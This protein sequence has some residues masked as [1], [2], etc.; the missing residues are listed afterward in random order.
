[1][2]LVLYKYAGLSPAACWTAAITTW[3]G[4]W[5]IFEPV[6]IPATSI[7]PF[8]LFPLVGV[9]DE[10]QVAA[11]YGHN[12]VLLFMGGFMIA[13]AL[14]KSGAHKR[15]AIIMVHAVGGK[16]GRRLVLGFMLASSVLSMWISNTAT[17]LM[18][19]P[20]AMAVLEQLDEGQRR[21]LAI[22]LML[23]LAYAASIGG[24]GTPIGTPPNV[25]FMGIW[26]QTSG[27]QMSFLEWMKIAVPVLAVMFPIIWLWL[28]RK[29]GKSQAV[30]LPE[31]GPWR[32]EERRVLIAFTLTAAA[33]IFRT[34]PKGGWS[35]LIGAAGA[36]DSTVA[37]VAVLALFVWPNGHGG[38]L[39]DWNT[40]KKIPWGILLMFGAGMTIAKAFDASGLSESIGNVLTGL[41]SWHPLTMMLLICIIIG[42]LTNVTSNTA[43]AALL[44]P[45][46][47][48]AA[49]AADINPAMMMLPA[50]LSTSCAFMLPVGTPPNAIVYGSGFITVKDM[51]REGFLVTLLGSIVVTLICYLLIPLLIG[52]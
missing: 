51:V 36:G 12:I 7:L 47:A 11:G 28:S 16:G 45:L 1:M 21:L 25:L 3:C 2:G 49:K 33:W 18:L 40:A 48:A 35:G 20:V 10:K 6:S 29:L 24:M 41:K 31:L 37:L 4:L 8:A 50:T 13:Q 43:M 23:G 17:T 9:M 14:E 26:Q 27:R 19:L 42:L 5:W 46:L 38:R 44:L 39:L 52:T 15:L 34:E 22:P 32:S 30:I